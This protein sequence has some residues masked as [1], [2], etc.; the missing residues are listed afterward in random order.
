[1]IN[2]EDETNPAITPLQDKRKY[3]R[4]SSCNDTGCPI[5][6]HSIDYSEEPAPTTSSMTVPKSVTSSRLSRNWP[7]HSPVSLQLLLP[8]NLRSII[9]LKPL[10]LRDPGW[11]HLPGMAT[12]T[13]SIGGSHHAPNH[14]INPTA[15]VPP[16]LNSC[17]KPCFSTRSVPLSTW[18]AGKSSNPNCST[19][20]E[21]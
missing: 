18:T 7:S 8:N 14:L 9:N 3:T 2:I 21:I 5:G 11:K 15:T 17:C 16:E 19:S 10:A 13:A 20:L 4:Q 6:W 1:M 12:N